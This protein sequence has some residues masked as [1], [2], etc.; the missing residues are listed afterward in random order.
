MTHILFSLGAA[1]LTFGV[2][3]L[4]TQPIAAVFPALVAGA[5]LFFYLSRKTSVEVAKALEGL[6]AL[7]KEQK[8]EE[9]I[10]HLQEIKLKYGK[11]QIL[12]ERQID[13]QIGLIRYIQMRFDEAFPL[14]ERGSWR[15][16]TALVAVGAIHYRRGEY[17]L[18][19]KRLE[20][21]GKVAPKEPFVFVV[22]AVLLLRQDQ[23][24]AALTALGEGLKG[25][26]KSQDL[27]RLQKLI[28][29]KQSVEVRSLPQMWYQFF[30]EELAAQFGG[31][32]PANG[33][34][35]GAGF[36]PKR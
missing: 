26:P 12:L 34:M 19:W 21:A 17:D 16:W 36:R 6:P 33:P 15:N 5:M 32:M 35:P 9:A 14:L 20:K 27:L 7:L 25:A 4:L 1:A 10:A 8:V 28:A 24:E 29:N 13:G 2:V 22:W 30:P 31:R 11:S 18:A 23:R 3:A